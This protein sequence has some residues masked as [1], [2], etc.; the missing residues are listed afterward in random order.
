MTD[1][2]TNTELES[3][4]L[5]IEPARVARSTQTQ[6]RTQ[7]TD[8]EEFDNECSKYATAGFLLGVFAVFVYGIATI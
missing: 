8:K 6:P 4:E 5:E 3:I 7:A 2:G 1:V